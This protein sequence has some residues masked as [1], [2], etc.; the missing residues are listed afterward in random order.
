MVRAGDA[1]C[2][3]LVVDG[4]CRGC[5][6]SVP[7]VLGYGFDLWLVDRNS[8]KYTLHVKAAESAGASLFGMPA[9][10]FSRLSKMELG[11]KIESVTFET[12]S[13]GIFYK[14]TDGDLV[15]VAFDMKR[16]VPTPTDS[17]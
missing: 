6:A 13:L 7:G 16:V 12:Y 2:T 11:E 3:G 14:V 10:E 17:E 8:S 1:P 15:T 5:R 4:V 9:S